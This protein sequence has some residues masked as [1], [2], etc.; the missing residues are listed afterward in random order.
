MSA[1]SSLTS[2]MVM[3]FQA[4]ERIWQQKQKKPK[5]KETCGTTSSKMKRQPMEWEK[6]FANY[7][8][9]KRLI[10][11]NVKNSGNSIA[12]FLLKNGQNI[13]ID[14]FSKK[15]YTWP[16]GTWQ[17]A[18]REDANQNHNEVLLHTCYNGHS[19]KDKHERGLVRMWRK[20]LSC[21]IGG[22]V[23]WWA[24]TVENIMEVP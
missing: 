12:N 10:D 8:S 7:V 24:A 16:P 19:R 11:K 15:A 23:N 20:K 21:T 17:G 13:C 18:H 5:Q 4:G 6:I 1:V 22:K 3:I 9:D 2:V 14:I